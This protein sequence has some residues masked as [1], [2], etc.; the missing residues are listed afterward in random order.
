MSLIM[1]VHLSYGMNLRMILLTIV[2]SFIAVTWIPIASDQR[3]MDQ[4]IK[5]SARPRMPGPQT[6][7]PEDSKSG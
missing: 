4:S 2:G 7:S 3:R 1:A 5:R 6:L